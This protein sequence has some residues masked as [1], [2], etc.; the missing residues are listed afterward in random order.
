[1]TL[2][3]VS[4]SFG[5]AHII[6]GVDLELR[7][8]ERHAFIGP[9]G[10]GKSTLFHLISGS[11]KPSAGE[12]LLGEVPIGGLGPERINRMGLARSFQITNIFPRLSVFENLRL[13]VM[14][15]FGM[16]YTLWRPIS[17]YRKVTALA[18]QLLE[19]VRLVRHRDTLGGELSYSEQRSLE[20]G[21]TLASDPKVLLLDE[22][23]AG[24][25]REETDYTAEL[26]R[27]LSV[28]RSLMI[29]EHDMD[30]VFS[31]C[32]R[33]SVLVYGQVVATGTPEEIRN[34]A[35]VQEAYLGKEVA[36]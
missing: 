10:A 31:L 25:S 29:V 12:I 19:Q 24:M 8:G 4:K 22:P 30:V 3:N 32:D 34:N 28:G 20:I 17:Q 15:R 21:M 27:E 6:R 26:L 7:R 9:N 33:I 11:F 14:Q 1:M 36:A 16:Q 13:G 5:E 2:R 23:M 35:Q 18:E